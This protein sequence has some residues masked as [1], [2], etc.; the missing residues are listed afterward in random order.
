MAEERFDVD[1]MVAEHAEIFLA[2]RSPP[3]RKIGRR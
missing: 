3:M 2:G 1:R